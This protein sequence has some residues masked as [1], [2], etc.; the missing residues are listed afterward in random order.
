MVWTFSWRERE[1]EGEREGE[2]K[3]ERWRE[4]ERKRDR[5]RERDRENRIKEINMRECVVNILCVL[6]AKKNTC[7]F[8]T[9]S[10]TF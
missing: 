3:R 6:K 10:E 5:E 4:I 7:F 2:R 9:F 1:R 8:S